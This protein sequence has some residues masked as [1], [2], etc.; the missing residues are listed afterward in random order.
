MSLQSLYNNQHTLDPSP[1]VQREGS[2][3][4]AKGIGLYIDKMKVYMQIISSF[5]LHTFDTSNSCSDVVRA[6]KG[7]LKEKEA[8]EASLKA[9]SIQQLEDDPQ[10]DKAKDDSE[11]GGGDGTVQEWT[12]E[13]SGENES[14]Q[15]N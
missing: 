4:E 1:T 13:E 10:E 7:L 9:L 3:N 15:A 8:L 11:G 14:S 6:Y 5:L 12:A 2:G